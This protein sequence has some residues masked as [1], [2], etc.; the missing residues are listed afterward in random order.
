MRDEERKLV[1]A[2]HH[3]QS[4]IMWTMDYG[5]WSHFCLPSYSIHI[6]SKRASLLLWTMDTLF[7]NLH[8]ISLASNVS[9]L[10]HNNNNSDYTY[11]WEVIILNF[12]IR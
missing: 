5:L 12:E 1:F 11:K 7:I 9:K 6:N 4:L 10:Y 8:P 3:Q 2:S